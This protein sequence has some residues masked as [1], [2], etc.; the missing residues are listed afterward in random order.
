M[1]KIITLEQVK[2][3]QASREENIE[4]AITKI[5]SGIRSAINSGENLY[6]HHCSQ[7]ECDALVKLLSEA[8]YEPVILGGKTAIN[9]PL[10]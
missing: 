6:Q 10:T 2:E 9:I 5:N 8:G 3:I 7:Y 4:K 1:E